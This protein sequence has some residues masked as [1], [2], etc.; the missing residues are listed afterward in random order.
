MVNIN[1]RG[2]ITAENPHRG[3]LTLGD[4]QQTH[5]TMCRLPTSKYQGLRW[6]DFAADRR[7]HRAALAA[8][9]HVLDGKASREET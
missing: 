6:A 2:W 9:K 3:V 7:K 8:G 4:S 5:R 1:V